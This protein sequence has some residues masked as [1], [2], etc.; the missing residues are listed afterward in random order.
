MLFVEC[1]LFYGLFVDDMV[2]WWFKVCV[3]LK[4]CI[5]VLRLFGL[6]LILY[7]LLFFCV[8]GILFNVLKGLLLV[9]VF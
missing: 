7:V 4:F 3:K 6:V 2:F 9:F 5:G 8:F 1:M